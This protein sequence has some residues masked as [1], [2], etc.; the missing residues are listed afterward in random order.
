MMNEAAVA[1]AGR[2]KKN[3]VVQKEIMNALDWETAS[4]AVY[5]CFGFQA[6]MH[7]QMLSFFSFL[8]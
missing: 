4:E 6:S 1:T 5:C 2:N 8:L 3:V 7:L